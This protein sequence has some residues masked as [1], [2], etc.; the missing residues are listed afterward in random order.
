MV[1]HFIS[2][3]SLF[4]G[5]RSFMF[6][7]VFPIQTSTKSCFLLNESKN[8]RFSIFIPS[9]SFSSL[10]APSREVSFWSTAPPVKFHLLGWRFRVFPLFWIKSSLLSLISQTCTFSLYSPC[11]GSFVFCLSHVLFI[12]YFLSLYKSTISIF[13]PFYKK[14]T[15][16]VIFFYY[17]ISCHFLWD[18]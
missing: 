14:T 16:V 1:T 7:F 17:Y 15:L 13:A 12:F 4:D 11:G 10:V 3:T 8:S 6:M 18:W 2:W 5:F 9:S